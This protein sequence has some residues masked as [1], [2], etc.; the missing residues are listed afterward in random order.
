MLRST[1]PVRTK[2]R[3]ARAL[4]WTF[5][6]LAV[7]GAIAY[8]F[9]HSGEQV[10]Q[11]VL[12]IPIQD[13]E[14]TLGPI[15]AVFPDRPRAPITIALPAGHHALTVERRGTVFLE[16]EVDLEAGDTLVLTAYDGRSEARP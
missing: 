4:S 6:F 10:G 2:G 9:C 16:Q 5:A 8:M 14:I 11:V 12:H 7:G 15:H 13:V 3:A 1:D